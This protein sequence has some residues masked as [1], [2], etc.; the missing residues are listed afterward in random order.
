MKAPEL[1]QLLNAKAYDRIR[2]KLKRLG[3]HERMT[4]LKEG[5]N[6][7]NTS[8][9]NLKFFKENFSV[10]IGAILVAKGDIDEAVSLYNRSKT[11]IK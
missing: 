7:I 5:F 1:N 4:S 6:L 9:A 8:A 3:M 2:K 11:K 10:E